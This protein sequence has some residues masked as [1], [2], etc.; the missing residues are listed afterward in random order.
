[1]GQGEQESEGERE[2]VFS[3]ACSSVPV[4]VLGG[5]GFHLLQLGAFSRNHPLM[6]NDR[7]EPIQC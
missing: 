7:H 3:S 5:V 2:T 6:A 1:M 4:P